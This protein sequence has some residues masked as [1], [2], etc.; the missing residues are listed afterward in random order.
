MAEEL[1][2]KI[3]SSL[4]KHNQEKRD[5]ILSHCNDMYFADKMKILMA[6]KDMHT[7]TG[8]CVNTIL[9]VVKR[10]RLDTVDF[11]LPEKKVTK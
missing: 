8:S 3:F 10:A 6:L 2:E 7:D 9:E 1:T 4:D 5:I 11:I